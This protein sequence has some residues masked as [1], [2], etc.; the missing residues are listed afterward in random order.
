M[1]RGNGTLTRR[2]FTTGALAASVLRA[3][4]PAKTVLLTL[5]DAVK[6]H[7]TFVGPLLKELG[8]SATFFITHNWMPDTQH[9]MSWK[10]VGELHQMGFEIG[11]HSWTHADFSSPRNA[12]RLAGELALV[13]NEL[14][15]VGVPKP[16]SFAYCGNSFGPEAVEVLRTAG[17]RFA[18]RGEMPEAPYGQLIVGATFDP[19]KHHRLLIPTTGDAYPNWTFEHFLKVISNAQEGRIVVLQFHGV[20]DTEHPWVHTPPEN[21]ERYMRYLKE[22]NFRVIALRDVAQYL[23]V[24]DPADPLLQDRSPRRKTAPPLP[25]EAQATQSDLAYWLP[26]MHA[27]RYSVEEASMVAGLPAAEISRKSPSP[28]DRTGALRVRPYPGG[29]PLRIGFQE[30]AINPLRGT[31][32]TVFLPWDPASYVVIDL[33]EAIFSNM[34][35]LF[36]AHTHVPTIWNDRNVVIENVDWVREGTGL[37]SN[38]KLPNDVGFGASIAPVED[39]IEMELWLRN[40]TAEPLSKLRTQICVLLKG[41]AGFNAQTDSNKTFGKEVATVRAEDGRRSILTEWERCGR[42][43]GNK[44]CPCLHSDPVLP[45]CAA[46]ETVRVR[47]KLWFA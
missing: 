37:R 28:P 26:N 24:A 31:K 17:Y 43:W 38:W 21:F 36:L 3:A 40:G 35:L 8:H 23:P 1:N 34:G 29:R 18:R 32:A 9:F 27:H 44:A 5:D 6:S 4:I 42:T 10:D 22:Q 12:A 11:N 14:K 45:D 46:G 20:P 13:E 33:P 41:A 7:R 2:S 19:A 16:V 15:R 25:V 39:R 30:G 47:G